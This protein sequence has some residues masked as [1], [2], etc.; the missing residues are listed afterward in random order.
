M[1]VSFLE[2]VDF[3]KLV[4]LSWVLE[5]P[6]FCC[7]CLRVDENTDTNTR[8]SRTPLSGTESLA[9]SEHGGPLID[10]LVG[11]EQERK[12]S[13]VEVKSLFFITFDS[14]SFTF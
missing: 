4:V 8:A 12:A 2:F 13:L 10:R 3:R 6:S 11:D 9:G 14:V 7:I 5:K 1:D